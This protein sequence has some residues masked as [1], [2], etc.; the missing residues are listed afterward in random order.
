MISN[1]MID[2]IDITF[3]VIKYLTQY[4]KGLYGM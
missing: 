3:P 4:C 2:S 1:E